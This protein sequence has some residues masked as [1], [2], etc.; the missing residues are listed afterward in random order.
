M[1]S[2]I[3]VSCY[4]SKP[5]NVIIDTSRQKTEIFYISVTTI[6]NSDSASL[7]ICALKPME[8]LYLGK[9]GVKYEICYIHPRSEECLK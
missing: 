3:T 1:Y 4:S 6:T 9:K 8:A 7:L 5:A 2:D